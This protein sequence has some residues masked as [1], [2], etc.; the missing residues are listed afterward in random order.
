MPG[1]KKPA[2]TAATSIEELIQRLEELARRIE[3]PDTGLE[4]SIALYQEGMAL[5]EQCRQ[6]LIETRKTLETI[7]PELSKTRSD[8][9]RPKDLF[10]L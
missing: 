3:N 6:R 8:P 5:A 7:N 4:N 1:S 9:A 2:D 10:G